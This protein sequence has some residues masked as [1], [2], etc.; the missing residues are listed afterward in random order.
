MRSLPA[1]EA[2]LPKAAAR[3]LEQVAPWQGFRPELRRR[4]AGVGSLGSRR[5]VAIGELAGGSVMREAKQIPGPASLWLGWERSGPRRLFDA[6]AA[7]RGI[8]ADPWRRQRGKWVLR[9]LAPDATR[10]ELSSLRRKH[11]ELAVLRS[12]GAEAANVHLLSHAMAAPSKA[13]AKDDDRRPPGWLH[14][15]AE[16]MRELTERDFQ[17]WRKAGSGGHSLR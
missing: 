9:P 10:L 16:V 14:E 4:V 7:S 3:L 13:L 17:E 6:V 11:D 12:M 5:I 15:A 1:F 8:A 2:R